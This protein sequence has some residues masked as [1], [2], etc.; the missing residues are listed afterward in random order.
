MPEGGG[1]GIFCTDSIWNVHGLHVSAVSQLFPYKLAE[2][3]IY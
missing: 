2:G 3:K 1:G